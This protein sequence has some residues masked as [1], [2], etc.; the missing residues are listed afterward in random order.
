[1]TNALEIITELFGPQA[2][3]RRFVHDGVQFLAYDDGSCTHAV[4]EKAVQSWHGLYPMNVQGFYENMVVHSSELVAT[5]ALE[6]GI[7]IH[8]REGRPVIAN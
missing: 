4:M 2:N 1:M 6:Q 7:V 8:S 3:P 5:S